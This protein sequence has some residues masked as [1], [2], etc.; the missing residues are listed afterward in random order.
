MK[1]VCGQYGILITPFDKNGINEIAY[2]NIVKKAI[3][4]QANGVVVSGTTSEFPYYSP[5]ASVRLL[6]IAIEENTNKKIIFSVCAPSIS[7]TI[8]LIK[9]GEKRGICEFLLCPPYYMPINNQ[10]D[11]FVFYEEVTKNINSTSGIVL[12][13]IPMCTQAIEI[14]LFEKLVNNPQIIGIKDSTGNFKKIVQYINLTKFRDDF[15]VLTGADEV[16]HYALLAGC[17]G[18]MTALGSILPEAG[19]FI[20]NH[21]LSNYEKANEIQQAIARLVVICESIVFPDGYKKLLALTGLDSGISMTPNHKT[22]ESI[23]NIEIKM[24][25]QL[26]ELKKIL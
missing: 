1:K 14:E 20:Y 10:E 8:W 11:I 22:K 13:N 5:E 4:S 7:Q 18:S 12:Y 24:I 9:E 26:E 16:L 6:D 19:A 2:R 25:K 21:K 23:D 15:S 3:S 17:D